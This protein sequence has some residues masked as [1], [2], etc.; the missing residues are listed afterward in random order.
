MST[1]RVLWFSV[2]GSAL[3]LPE[4]FTWGYSRDQSPGAVEAD[5]DFLGVAST[6][7]VLGCFGLETVMDIVVDT[8]AGRQLFGVGLVPD[9]DLEILARDLLAIFFRHIGE[10]GQIMCLLRHPEE[11]VAADDAGPVL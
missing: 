10:E 8:R 6:D 4:D 2:F 9:S 3:G 5:R 1:I 7:I 11:F